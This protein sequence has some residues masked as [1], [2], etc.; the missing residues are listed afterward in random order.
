MWCWE[1]PLGFVQ[2]AIKTMDIGSSIKVLR[3]QKKMTQKDL[4]AKCDL[5]PTALCN[6]EK[7]VSFPKKDTIEKLC[8][9]LGIPESYLLLF[10]LTEDDVP[11]DKRTLYRLLC[12][13]FQEELIKN[14]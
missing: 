12:K 7:G 13:P 6:L 1:V 11:A 14:L 3:K 2:L 8:A 4:A 10:S 9:G 5:T